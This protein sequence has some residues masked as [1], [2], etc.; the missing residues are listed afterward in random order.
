[1][2]NIKAEVVDAWVGHIIGFFFAERAEHS[3]TL[4]DIVA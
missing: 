2:N 3:H 1:M 4:S